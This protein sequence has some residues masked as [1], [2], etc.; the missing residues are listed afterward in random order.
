ML[1]QIIEELVNLRGQI[2]DFIQY[3][4]GEE[5]ATEDL[6]LRS[7]IETSITNFTLLFQKMDEIKKIF[8]VLRDGYIALLKENSIKNKSK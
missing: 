6:F 8:E 4:S 1:T 3:R 2:N 7:N 5:D